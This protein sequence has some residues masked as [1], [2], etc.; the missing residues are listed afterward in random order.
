MNIEN[1]SH[2]I[3]H[4]QWSI[5]NEIQ[6]ASAYGLHLDFQAHS[7]ANIAHSICCGISLGKLSP[8]DMSNWLRSCADHLDGGE[9][10][11]PDFIFYEGRRSDA[12]Q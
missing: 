7:I 2:L 3:K 10:G 11:L 6:T 9:K 4:H 12:V 8:S 5:Q 1:I